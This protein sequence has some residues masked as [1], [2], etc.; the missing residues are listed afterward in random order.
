MG[1]TAT[2]LVTTLGLVTVVFAGYYLYK[3]QAAGALDLTSK[4][5]Q[6]M[7]E[8]LRNTQAFIGHG[9]TLSAVQL[10]I[11]LFEDERFRSLKSYSTPILERPI[12]R[13]DPFAE[14][15]VANV[16]S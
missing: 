1:K 4:N 15:A 13:P 12:G 2:N 5:E 3:Q 10:D 14:P 11:S 16:T 7:Q 9:Q 6:V 8:M